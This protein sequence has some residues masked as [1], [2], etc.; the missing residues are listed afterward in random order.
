MLVTELP[1]LKAFF[2][3]IEVV[4]F[5]DIVKHFR[6]FSTETKIIPNVALVVM[7]LLVNP[8]T[9]ASAERSFSLFR[10]LKTWQR[11]T[12]TQKQYN[13]LAILQEHKARTDTLN[14]ID[15]GNEFVSKYQQQQITFSKFENSDMCY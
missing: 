13:S 8:S 5:D 2:N 4:C 14:L 7:L 12:M 9:S 1:V 11:S 15:I 3:D 6:N 10:R